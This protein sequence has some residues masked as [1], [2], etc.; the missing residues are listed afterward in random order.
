MIVNYDPRVVIFFIIA[1]GKLVMIVILWYWA[2]DLKV[3]IWHWYSKFCNLIFPPHFLGHHHLHFLS[4]IYMCSDTS[5]FCHV[6]PILTGC[7]SNF[8]RLSNRF[9]D[10]NFPISPFNFVQCDVRQS[11]A[12]KNQTDGLAKSVGQQKSDRFGLFHVNDPLRMPFP[13]PILFSLVI[14]FLI[15]L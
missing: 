6:Q 15:Q 8:A 1:K 5:Y 14:S 11:D 10:R 2:Y 13:R 7:L 9:W 12:Y 4:P 3:I